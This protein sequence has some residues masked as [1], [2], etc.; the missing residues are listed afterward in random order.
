[1]IL[2][3]PVWELFVNECIGSW[4]ELKKAV[5]KIFGLSLRQ[6]LDAFDSM[7]PENSEYDAEFIL[8]VEDKRAKLR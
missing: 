1:M 6:L 2:G 7:K 5:E 8:R 4:E 3:E